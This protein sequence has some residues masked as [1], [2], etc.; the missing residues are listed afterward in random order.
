VE[1]HEYLASIAVRRDKVRQDCSIWSDLGRGGLWGILVAVLNVFV[2][3]VLFVLGDLVEG[4]VSGRGLG[5]TI[6]MGIDVVW[7][8]MAH[9]ARLFFAPSLV[10]GCSLAL[11][12]R[13]LRARYSRLGRYGLWVGAS[14]GSAVALADL[15]FLFSVVGGIYAVF[16]VLIFI[17]QVTVYAWIGWR[18]ALSYERV[19]QETQT[20]DLVQ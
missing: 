9:A 20:K 10:G 15:L 6:A 2:F 4:I 5:G 14:V 19:M 17:V 16:K 1:D 8:G 7:I 12:V 18:L 3:P 11:A 13:F